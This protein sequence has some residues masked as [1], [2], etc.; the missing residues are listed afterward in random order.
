MGLLDFET[1]QESAKRKRNEEA[2]K[3]KMLKRFYLIGGIILFIILAAFGF[4][5]YARFFNPELGKQIGLE[6]TA[7]EFVTMKRLS[8]CA[9]F[10]ESYCRRLVFQ[11]RQTDNSRLPGV[12]VKLP[13]G[14]SVY[15]P[16]D[17]YFDHGAYY[18]D[19]GIQ[20][21]IIFV[22]REVNR[23]TDG[24]QSGAYTNALFIAPKWKDIKKYNE[25]VKKGDLI[26]IVDGEGGM[27]KPIIGDNDINLVV[28]VSGKWHSESGAAI[29][30][31]AD[32]LKEYIKYAEQKPL[33]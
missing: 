30:Q 21:P 22:Y 25:P 1:P 14:T 18:D 2:E 31:P 5:L 26:G 4:G 19:E 16:F 33:E 9:V 6:K 32:Y 17:G 24:L 13:A 3:G 8:S 11:N 15:A 20:R 28:D 7:I 27:F 10:E 29:A 12:G 23:T